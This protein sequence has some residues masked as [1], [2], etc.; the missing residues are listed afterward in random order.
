MY[1]GAL[2]PT[3]DNLLETGEKK[4]IFGLWRVYKRLWRGHKH[5]SLSKDSKKSVFWKNL[6][7]YKT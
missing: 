2:K 5:L 3:G 1:Q 6:K 4:D 7:K